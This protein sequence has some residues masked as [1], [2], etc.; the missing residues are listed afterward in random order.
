MKCEEMMDLMQSS[1]DHDLTA[2]EDLE[3]QAHLAGC[4]ECADLYVRLKLLND[5][6]AQLPMVKPAYSIVDAIMPQLEALPLWDRDG[7]AE[8]PGTAAALSPDLKPDNGQALPL[9]RKGGLFSWKIF[10]GVAAA[11]IVLGMFVFN[12]NNFMGGKKTASESTAVRQDT[13]SRESGVP[14]SAGAMP[15][16]EIM[17]NLPNEQKEKA[18]AAAGG[19]ATTVTP[20]GDGS[21]MK[22]SGKPDAALTQTQ[23]A[24]K[25]AINREQREVAI[26]S[27]ADNGV[28]TANDQQ[29]T[30]L[31]QQSNAS[32]GG[33]QEQQGQQSD[34]A[35][36]SLQPQGLALAID[37][38]QT[39]PSE[40]GLAD[41]PTRFASNEDRN[42]EEESARA[43]RAPLAGQTIPGDQ[44]FVGKGIIAQPL[45]S[46]AIQATS[47]GEDPITPM[48]SADGAYTASIVEHGVSIMAKDGTRVFASSVIMQPGDKLTFKGWEEGYKFVYLLTTASG[49]ETV[50]WISVAEN[51]EWSESK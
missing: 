22:L 9:R 27:P 23:P 10:T 2:E 44:G 38:E 40:G 25:D 14:Q 35:A 11:G 29:D 12:E 15:R 1:L 24:S 41:E 33:A 47:T 5:E 43:D 20:T 46:S 16:Q 51:K 31:L 7:S 3:L 34:A 6:L 21:A 32:G 8:D 48:T 26:A 45:S 17:N 19:A 49:T 39:K 37:P 13:D 42:P 30:P 28:G 4:T 18:A 50:Y 36:D